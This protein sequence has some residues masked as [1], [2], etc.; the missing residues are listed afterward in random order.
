MK[1]ATGVLKS[2]LLPRCASALVLGCRHPKRTRA[3]V[4]MLSSAALARAGAARLAASLEDYADNGFAIVRGLLS[5]AEVD[6][7]LAE[8]LAI[9]RGKGNVSGYEA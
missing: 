4:R 6:D 3:G 9:C 8:M 7:L 2:W 5:R 1:R